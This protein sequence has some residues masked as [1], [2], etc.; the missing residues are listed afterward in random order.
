MTDAL[1]CSNTATKLFSKYLLGAIKNKLIKDRTILC[2]ASGYDAPPTSKHH[3][4]HLLARDNT[5]LWI[6]YHGSRVPSV[7]TSDLSYICKKLLQV[8]RGLK[9]PHKNLYVLSKYL[10][11]HKEIVFK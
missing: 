8:F 7:S 4:M 6:N 11:S 2:F 1:I 10:L 5:V 9:N 3:V